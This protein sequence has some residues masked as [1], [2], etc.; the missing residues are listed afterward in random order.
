[1]RPSCG[2]RR[3][4]M[5]SFASTLRRVVTPAAI[6]FG[7]RCTSR[8]TPSTRKRT[9]SASS[10]GLEVD[11]RGVLLGRLED[12]GV[13]ET[14]ERAVGDPVVGLEVVAVVAD[15]VLE[16]DRDDGADRL[17][18]ANE[19]LQL[20]DDVVARR[21]DELERVLRR[22][23]KLVDRVQVPGIRDRDR[24]GRRPRARTARRPS[25]RASAPE[26]AA[27]PRRRRRRPGG[28]RPAG[29]DG[30]PACERCRRLSRRPPRS[31]P[32]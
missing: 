27:R 4:A 22:E 29:D 28:R 19:S 14:D 5:S 9:T 32:A 30:R 1:M 31:A 21:D 25:A 15:V 11:V 26:S 23:P 13:D 2:L 20:G 17:G 8:R 24:E 18:G 7:T 6:F 12:Q 3:S 16:I 10:C